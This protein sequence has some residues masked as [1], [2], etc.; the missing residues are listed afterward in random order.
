MLFV[1]DVHDS[2][3]ALRKLVATGEEVAILGDL[4]NLN[5]YRTGRGAVADVLGADFAE[6]TADAR[7]RGDYE[8][9]RELWGEYAERHGTDL[10]RDIG[11]AISEQYEAVGD[12][13]AGGR[14]LVIH[15]NVDR[16]DELR[17]VLPENWDYVHGQRVERDG[18]TFGFIGGGVVTPL[19]AAGEISDE[20]MA[21]L[22]DGLGEVDVLCTH[23]PAA[24][25]A[26]RRDVITGRIERGSS[27]IL[28]YIKA[29]QPRLHISGDVHQPQATSWRV[30]RTRCFNVSYFRAT[31]RYLR[32][33]GDIVM[34]GGVG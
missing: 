19:K 9:M 18:S 34:V 15:G 8:L 13:L 30:G 32:L 11:R 6:K 27:P 22:L 10:R 2:P 17:S 3:N 26:M 28:D 20:E 1:S 4:V 24:V 5:D 25:P 14:G 23:V 12:A 7:A 33:D 31:G 21:S 29:V 16:P